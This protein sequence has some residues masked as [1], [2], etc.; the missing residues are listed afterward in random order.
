MQGNVILIIAM[1]V[2]GLAL[3]YGIGFDRRADGTGEMAE[4]W[5]KKA[6][7][8]LVFVLFLLLSWLLARLGV[9]WGNAG[10]PY[11]RE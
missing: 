5:E 4:W 2:I 1:I 9:S 11:D 6:T 10:N 3:R 8:V 7:P